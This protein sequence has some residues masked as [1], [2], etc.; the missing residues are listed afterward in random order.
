VYG[1]CLIDDGAIITA[2]N[3]I[4]LGNLMAGKGSTIKASML[5]VGKESEV[6]GAHLD[7]VAYKKFELEERIDELLKFDSYPKLG[8]KITDMA[9]KNLKEYFKLNLTDKQEKQLWTKEGLCIGDDIYRMKKDGS[10]RV[11]MVCT[12][13]KVDVEAYQIFMNLMSKKVARHRKNS[14]IP[15]KILQGVLNRID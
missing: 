15:E 6:T 13:S 12:S 11:P 2:N 3:F 8:N 4:V 9:V 14:E 5:L 10:V 7:G 1:D